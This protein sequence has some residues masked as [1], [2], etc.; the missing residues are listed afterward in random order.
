[1]FIFNADGRRLLSKTD[2]LTSKD[3]DERREREAGG[4]KPLNSSTVGI[5]VGGEGAGWG[6][7]VR[8]GGFLDQNMERN[9]RASYSFFLKRPDTNHLE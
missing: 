3:G 2:N 5:V 7:Y 6:E 9:K 8:T 1:M 4:Q